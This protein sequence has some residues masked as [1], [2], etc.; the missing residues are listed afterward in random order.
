M[1]RAQY[2]TMFN[3]LA[4]TRTK[5]TECIKITRADGTIFRFTAHDEPLT[6]R[7]PEGGD[8]LYLS[9]NSFSLTTIETSI[10]LVVSNMDI[11][12][13]IDDDSIT[14]NDLRSGLFDNANVELFIAYW[15][16]STVNI[17]PLRTSWI[18]EIQVDGPKF[19]VDLRGIA[20]KLAQVFIKGTS[21]ECRYTFGDADCGLSLAAFTHTYTIATVESRDIFTC[22]IAA[23]EH[24][25]TFQW[26]NAKWLTGDNA[27]T[28]MEVL[29]QFETRVQLFLPM[30]F[31]IQVGDTLELIEGCN[32]TWDQCKAFG[33]GQFFG[34]EPYLAGGDLL[35]RVPT[36]GG[37]DDAE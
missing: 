35:T 17:L 26:G 5:Y 12:G 28:E 18:G 27:G 34:G 29:H 25:N 9:A 14:E 15:S 21:L 30:K 19:K 8:F 33:N 16:N 11:D 20:Q 22:N 31:T 10:G 13:L 24:A 2:S 7:E 32:K 6:V 36:Y 37:D 23:P 4:R 3:L 1:N